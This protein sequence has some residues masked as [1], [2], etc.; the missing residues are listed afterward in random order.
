MFKEKRVFSRIKLPSKVSI[1]FK[2]NKYP[3]KLQNISLQGATLLT[4]NMISLNKGNR[5]VLKISPFENEESLKLEALAV[6]NEEDRIGIQFCENK[7]HV[8]RNLH[9][10]ISTHFGNPDH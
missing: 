1:K 4:K 8:V 5:C 9:N 3:V 10:L 7:P 6:Y 2:D